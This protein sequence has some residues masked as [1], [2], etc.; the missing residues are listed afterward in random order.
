MESEN[1]WTVE[2]HKIWS[3]LVP[4]NRQRKLNTL[5]QILISLVGN[6]NSCCVWLL[7]CV[8]AAAITP[9]EQQPTLLVLLSFHFTCKWLRSILVIFR[10][11]APCNSGLDITY[12]VFR[13]FTQWQNS[14]VVT[15][16]TSKPNVKWNQTVQPW[17]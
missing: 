16:I 15:G 17:N 7:K 10:V 14:I 1:G 13:G 4:E 3:I 8:E 12:S 9:F 2:W 11:D 5:C 6:A